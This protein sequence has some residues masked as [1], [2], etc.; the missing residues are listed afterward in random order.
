MTSAACASLV[1]ALVV[2]CSD[3]VKLDNTVIRKQR[4]ARKMKH[5]Q[6]EIQ[7]F[8]KLMKHVQMD[9]EQCTADLHL[10][11]SEVH[12]SHTYISLLS[13]ASVICL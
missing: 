12:F 6:K 11:L 4:L 1:L 3:Q 5:E 10:K 8:S 9:N 13:L 2:L 7:D